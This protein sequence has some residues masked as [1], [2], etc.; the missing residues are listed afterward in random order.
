MK[1]VLVLGCT[2]SIGTNTLNIAN[3]LPQDFKICGLQSHSNEKKLYELGRLY[4]CPTLL[5]SKDSSS[6]AF[7]KLIIESK[8]DIVV[9][10]IA[11]AAGLLPSKIVLENK[12]DI[13]LANKELL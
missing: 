1:R 7:E 12:I 8:P 9:N 13:A 4:D 6:E 11:G 3:N 10:G 5:T 2:G